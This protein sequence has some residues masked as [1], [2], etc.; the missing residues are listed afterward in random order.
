MALVRFA[1]IDWAERYGADAAASRGGFQMMTEHEPP[2]PDIVWQPS[3]LD[4]TER[5]GR[6]D[7]VGATIWLTGLPASGKSTIAAALE[8]QLVRRGRL[9][10]RL[11]G[12]NV[13]HG[14]SSDLGF[15]Q[16]SRAENV[17]RVAHVAEFFADAGGIALVALV[18]PYA[19]DRDV[20]RR[21]HTE[22]GLAF[23]EVFVDTPLEECVRR[24]PKGLYARARSGKLSG[25]TGQS[26]P[27]ERPEAPEVT[28]RTLEEP[29]TD[30]VD[31]LIALIESLA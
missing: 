13:R 10:Y 28:V 24:D 4:R 11:D 3:K 20:A 14:L 15:D 30:A 1:A 5:W 25:L 29:V 26:S 18:S 2:S 21:L 31:R 6:L 23:V 9:A 22:A 7:T 12:D 17:R 16:A 8:Q 19:A 27:Y